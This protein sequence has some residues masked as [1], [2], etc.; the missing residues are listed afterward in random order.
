MGR[1][2]K[3]SVQEFSQSAIEYVENGTRFRVIRLH[4]KAMTVEL[5]LFND[6]LKT[7]SKTIPFA[8]LPKKIKQQIRPL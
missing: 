4:E 2:K 8:H 1:S 5:W 3:P 6:G 7:G